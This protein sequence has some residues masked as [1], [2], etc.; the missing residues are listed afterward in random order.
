MSKTLSVKFRDL[1]VDD[2]QVK[3]E[4]LQ[5]VDNVLTHGQ[6]LLGPEVELLE[7]KLAD[8]CGREYCVGVASGT[9][10]LYLALVGLGIGSGD[11]VITTPLSWIATLNAIYQCGAKAVFVDIN[12]DLNMN[13]DLLEDAITSRTKVIM[14][15]HFTGRLC[16]M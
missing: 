13:V 15:V 7:K 16:N 2:P 14:P 1:S 5:A 8:Y 4:L 10:A 3:D 12:E 6:L 11:E 9:D